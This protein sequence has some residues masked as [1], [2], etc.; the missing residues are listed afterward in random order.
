MGL[1]AQLLIMVV[2]LCV[3]QVSCQHMETGCTFESQSISVSEPEGTPLIL[4]VDI[5]I[6]GLREVSKS[7][8]SFGID[9]E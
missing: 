2:L 8:G 9:V 3:G 1:P 7:G 5:L 6:I 4:G